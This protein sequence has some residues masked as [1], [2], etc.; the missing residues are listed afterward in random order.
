MK[1]TVHDRYGNEIYLTD[2][3]WE[4]II[5]LHSEM[6]PFKDSLFET[7]KQ[8]Q[9]KQDA[10]DMTTYKY[11][12]AYNDL[13]QDNNFIIVVVK[14]KVDAHSGANNFVLTAYQKK[15]R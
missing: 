10:A 6:E 8:G 9:R 13:E 14:F 3:R 4:H 5:S 7:L 15:T 12:F 11:S 2:E 1:Q